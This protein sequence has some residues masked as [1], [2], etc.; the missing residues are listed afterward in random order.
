MF[1]SHQTQQLKRDASVC[2]REVVGSR[3]N[4]VEL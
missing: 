3:M 2:E 1:E 4:V